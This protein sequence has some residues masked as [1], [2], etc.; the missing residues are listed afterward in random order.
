MAPLLLVLLAPGA[1]G[2]FGY[3]T[4][5][6]DPDDTSGKPDIRSTTRTVFRNEHG[7]FRLSVR[8]Y[9]RLGPVWGEM[10]AYLDA[11]GGPRWDHRIALVNLEGPPYCSLFTRHGGGW[12]DQAYQKRYT[13][14]CRFRLRLLRRTKRIRWFVKS[15][16]N[17][18]H[19]IDRA[20]DT[21]WNG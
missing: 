5:G 2:D 13:V 16:P 8:A 19:V 1:S 14:K 15:E 21:G 18:D 11:R 3:T 20:P 6:V 17:E 7:W 4:T 10:F 9:D 12:A